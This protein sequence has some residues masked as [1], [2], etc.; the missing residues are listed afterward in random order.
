[1]SNNQDAST[2][3][4]SINESDF[5]AAIKSTGSI[6]DYNVLKAIGK[7]KFSV[8]YRAVEKATE[9]IVALKRIAIVDITDE[10]QRQKTLKEVRLLQLGISS[11][12]H[13]P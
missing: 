13:R 10:R 11:M 4:T 1:M 9:K 3:S 5:A 12:R 8:V 6:Q 7:G 2:E